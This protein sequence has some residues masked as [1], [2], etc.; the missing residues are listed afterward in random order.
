MQYKK[1]LFFS[2]SSRYDETN[3][4]LTRYFYN[5]SI[6]YS[7]PDKT[8]G[9]NEAMSATICLPPYICFIDQIEKIKVIVNMR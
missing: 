1:N 4:T 8:S 5:S 9:P 2:F 6:G 7:V 3:N